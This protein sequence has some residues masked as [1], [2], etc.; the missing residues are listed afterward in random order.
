[1]FSAVLIFVLVS[2]KFNLYFHQL[3]KVF[4]FILYFTSLL[5]TFLFITVYVLPA[6]QHS[7]LHSVCIS[8]IA[9]CIVLV[10]ILPS[11]QH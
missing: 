10:L 1:M 7:G 4:F 5:L 6:P 8:S 11:I 9:S 3:S 2:F